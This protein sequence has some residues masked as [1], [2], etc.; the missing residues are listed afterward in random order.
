MKPATIQ[1]ID[2]EGQFIRD[3]K[4][5]VVFP[6]PF[7]TCIHNPLHSSDTSNQNSDTAGA[8]ADVMLSQRNVLTHFGGIYDDECLQHTPVH[9]N[10]GRER[11]S[12]EGGVHYLDRPALEYKAKN[13]FY[14][15]LKWLRNCVKKP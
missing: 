4:P 11:R 6:R 7:P 14:S 1:P 12:T 9:W 8:V 5:A 2:E 15:L 3:Q 10:F 13:P